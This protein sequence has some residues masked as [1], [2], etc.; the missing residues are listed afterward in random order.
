MDG[1][2]DFLRMANGKNYQR[3]DPEN[4]KHVKVQWRKPAN[5]RLLNKDQGASP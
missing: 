4:I 5:S 3:L 2:N 1:S